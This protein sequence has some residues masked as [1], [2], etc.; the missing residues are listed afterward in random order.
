[1]VRVFA[2]TDPPASTERVTR[3]IAPTKQPTMAIGTM[4][5]SSMPW[6][7]SLILMETDL[8]REGAGMASRILPKLMPIEHNRHLNICNIE[9]LGGR[10][11]RRKHLS[12]GR[13]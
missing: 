3:I 8:S 10:S 11:E 13:G 12:P 1:M 9:L 5:Q 2:E 4:A 7:L 6:R